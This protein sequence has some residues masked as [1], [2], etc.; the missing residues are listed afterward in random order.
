[1][2]TATDIVK[3]NRSYISSSDKD[4][5]IYGIEDLKFGQV[6]TGPEW[7]VVPANPSNRIPSK[8]F[9]DMR[10][11]TNEKFSQSLKGVPCLL[12]LLSLD[13]VLCGGSLSRILRSNPNERYE[14]W[15]HDYDLFIVRKLKSRDLLNKL[16]FDA[17][18]IV[19]KFYNHAIVTY[20]GKTVTFFIRGTR[21]MSFKIQIVLR[22][23]DSISQVLHGFDLGSSCVAFDG[24]RLYFTGAGKFAF[25]Y[26]LNVVDLERRSTSFE[27]RLRKYF[28]LG[29]GFVMPQFSLANAADPKSTITMPKMRLYVNMIDMGTHSIYVMHDKIGVKGL[30]SSDY[31]CNPDDFGKKY[32]LGAEL[33]RFTHFDIICRQNLAN[34]VNNRNTFTWMLIGIPTEWDLDN[35]KHWV[36]NFGALSKQQT[37]IFQKRIKF[38][39]QKFNKEGLVFMIANPTT[40]QYGMHNPVIKNAKDWYGDYLLKTTAVVSKVQP[41]W[42]ALMLQKFNKLFSCYM[43]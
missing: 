29:F 1:M 43:Q 27:S 33:D 17:I 19:K 2:I 15:T 24:D 26:Q 11:W 3:I 34:L 8:A 12:E 38:E 28:A 14:N 7:K 10:E 39:E 13:V 4:F 25:E 35:V 6:Y 22:V 40:Q 41:D 21:G 31:E 30:Q 37:E 32:P 23:Y 5:D 20:N 16:I 36:L 9:Y 18:R 42:F